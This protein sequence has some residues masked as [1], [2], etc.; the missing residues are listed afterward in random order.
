MNKYAAE[1]YF[2]EETKFAT[3]NYHI[4]VNILH[5][6]CGMQV[7]VVQAQFSHVVSVIT[8]SPGQVDD[9]QSQMV[10]NGIPA[11]QVFQLDDPLIE[12]MRNGGIY[13]F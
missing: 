3:Q 13:S 5:F 11:G 2:A 9:P 1:I 8:F 10:R 4:P 6:R 12:M 7:R